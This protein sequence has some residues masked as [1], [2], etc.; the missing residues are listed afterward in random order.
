M[1]L[2]SHSKSSDAFATIPYTFSYREVA[3][4]GAGGVRI[5]PVCQLYRPNKQDVLSKPPSIHTPTS[6]TIARST[7][8]PDSNITDTAGAGRLN[9]RSIRHTTSTEKPSRPLDILSGFC[10]RAGEREHARLRSQD[11][12]MSNSLWIHGSSRRREGGR[13]RVWVP[14]SSFCGRMLRVDHAGIHTSVPCRSSA[15]RVL[16]TIPEEKDGNLS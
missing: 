11:L 14:R 5:P 16:R 4:K 15:R 10:Q 13:S 3:K 6:P 7:T 2:T 12:G 8:R 9:R 1:I